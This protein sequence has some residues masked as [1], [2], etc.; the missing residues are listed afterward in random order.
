MTARVTKA[1]KDDTLA[2]TAAQGLVPAEQ[3]AFFTFDY[4]FDELDTRYRAGFIRYHSHCTVLLLLFGDPRF[5][6]LFTPFYLSASRRFYTYVLYFFVTER[7][8]Y[9]VLCWRLDNAL[10]RPWALQASLL[11]FCL[12]SW[13]T[14][15]DRRS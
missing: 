10:I 1:D 6:C 9:I 13:E 5:F 14:G 8:M 2:S 4:C 3:R 11:L 15:L 7:M 12:M